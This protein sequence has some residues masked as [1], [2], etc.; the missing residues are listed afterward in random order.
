MRL[1]L[2]LL[3]LWH[4]STAHAWSAFGEMP[5][6]LREAAE[7]VAAPG[8]VCVLANVSTGSY[9]AWPP[10]DVPLLVANATLGAAEAG[11][12]SYP[13]VVLQGIGPSSNRYNVDF[14]SEALLVDGVWDIS[15][16]HDISA[17]AGGELPR[18]SGERRLSFVDVGAHVGSWTYGFAR[19]GYRV[20][21]IEALLPNVAALHAT[22]CLHRGVHADV[23]VTI[24]PSVVG[25]P[26]QHGP[27]SLISASRNNFGN[28]ELS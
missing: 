7:S 22:L 23:D 28:A 20:I 18:P 1:S 13:L 16:L 24:V 27:C 21:S 25:A 3:L 17:A 11:V 2:R 19:A 15:S 9:W 26:S 5:T 10:G 4:F 12:S 14:A 6:C 8:G